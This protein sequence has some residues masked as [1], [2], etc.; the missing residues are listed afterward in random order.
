MDARIRRSVLARDG[1]LGRIGTLTRRITVA[2]VAGALVLMA[3]FA[4]LLPTHLPH[5]STSQNGAG[6]SGLQGPQSGP[7]GGNG[8]SQVTSG[9]S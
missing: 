7:G 8:P 1:A 2:S 6:S 3:G 5:V 4:H 9:G